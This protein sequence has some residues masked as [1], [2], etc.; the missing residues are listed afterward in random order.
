MA[1]FS[2]SLVN[3]YGST[4]LTDY[5]TSNFKTAGLTFDEHLNLSA[6]GSTL[7]FSMLKYLYE[8]SQ[9]VVNTPTVSITYGS[10]IRCQYNGQQYDFAV[11]NISYQ[12]LAENLQL[13]FSAQDYFQFETSQLG[14]G[15][16]ITSDTTDPNYFGAQPIDNWAYKII[17]DNNLGWGYIPIN[18]ANRDW[19]NSALTKQQKEYIFNTSNNPEDDYWTYTSEEYTL[20]QWVSFECSESSAYNALKQLASDNG[21]ILMVDYGSHNCWFAPKQNIV[22]HGYYFNPLNNLQQFAVKGSAQNLITVLNV[23]GPQDLN[24]QE[25]TLVPTLPDGVVA[26]ILSDDWLNSK[27]YS[28][29]YHNYTD[30]LQF[31][32]E[33]AYTPWL[34]NKL[35]DY[36]FF[37]DNHLLLP[38]EA[39]RI[40]D[41][42]YDKLR[43]IN[44]RMLVH[45][46]QYLSRYGEQYQ[47]NTQDIINAES[48]NAGLMG[49]VAQIANLVFSDKPACFAVSD[50]DGAP[51]IYWPETYTLYTTQYGEITIPSLQEGGD[52]YGK[53]FCPE[54]G[55]TT[56]PACTLTQ[57]NNSI[58]TPFT[59]YI[60]G[61]AYKTTWFLKTN[62]ALQYC[63]TNA[64]S[65]TDMPTN[66]K[67]SVSFPTWCT[68]FRLELPQH[69][70]PKLVEIRRSGG[71]IEARGC[72]TTDR[73]QWS[74]WT[75]LTST[76]TV[77]YFGTL[78]LIGGRLESDVSYYGAIRVMLDYGSFT[79]TWAYQS[80]AITL[81]FTL[82]NGNLSCSRSPANTTRL[83]IQGE[84]IT[85]DSYTFPYSSEFITINVQAIISNSDAPIRHIKVLTGDLEFYGRDLQG[86]ETN[87]CYIKADPTS[88]GLMGPYLLQQ[89][90]NALQFTQYPASRNTEHSATMVDILNQLC[91]TRDGLSQTLS[92]N[93]FEF[94]SAWDKIYDSY[95][96]ETLSSYSNV[97]TYILKLQKVSV[98]NNPTYDIIH[99]SDPYYEGAVRPN[100]FTMN[101][102]KFLKAAIL[103]T[104]PDRPLLRTEV[105]AY[106][107]TTIS[108][109]TEKWHNCYAAATGLGIYWPAD[110]NN[111]DWMTSHAELVQQQPELIQL[112]SP[113][114][115]DGTGQ[116]KIQNL[117]PN[118]ALFPLVTN[119]TSINTQKANWDL[120][121]TTLYRGDHT[122][123]VVISGELDITQ[124]T[125]EPTHYTID[126]LTLNVGNQ[127]PIVVN[128]ATFILSYQYDP[129]TQQTVVTLAL[130]KPDSSLKKVSFNIT[131][132]D[133]DY[134]SLQPQSQLQVSYQFVD[135]NIYLAQ[136]PMPISDNTQLRPY[137]IEQ[138]DKLDTANIYQTAWKQHN[139][140]ND[141]LKLQAILHNLSVWR[142]SPNIGATIIPAQILSIPFTEA[143]YS[144]DKDIAN[145][146]IFTIYSLAQ[147][148]LYDT[149]VYYEMLY[150]HNKYW[151]TLYQDYPGIFRESAYSNTTATNSQELYVAAKAELD[152]LS[153]PAFEYTLAGMDIY[154]YN[155]DF[156]PTRL[157]LGDQIRVDYQDP[158]QLTD[159]LN[160]ALREPLYI[161][162]ISHTLRNDGDYQFTVITRTA[163][164][165]MV[166][167]FAK[168]LNFGR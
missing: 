141:Q 90:H 161:T 66:Q 12:F 42:L 37:Q 114:I 53:L 57:I 51:W 46:R 104:A 151:Q 120:V 118:L 10:L 41:I 64:L 115:F 106:L 132:Y 14:I 61:V 97:G 73:G 138:S 167:R 44:G 76:S 91:G 168:L 102:I 29:L 121:V 36:S 80:S 163:T 131:V 152:N 13:T 134:Q 101:D 129:S 32:R 47:Q 26:W 148:V 100:V 40:Q 140:I 33:V 155:S 63:G 85:A 22:F 75:T 49:D 136:P 27:Y 74:D 128:T 62:T 119:S 159:T 2:L 84:I 1:Q 108:Y 60:N 165:S 28:N 125:S 45:Q 58:L 153:K 56:Y 34:E 17:Q 19:I 146:N 158:D 162:G 30:N 139:G 147:R 23:S 99:A 127:L 16:T 35:I 123:P 68:K 50:K 88:E 135:N 144:A 83:Q 77:G 130:D 70:A 8:G 55:G 15:Y 94:L 69:G 82:N 52:Y 109:F 79:T 25:I 92:Q 145:P 113:L 11:T 72:N 157:K 71:N 48:L 96:N 78:R 86:T 105:I 95:Q 111:S 24:N 38:S 21:F 9:K 133:T 5:D 122:L 137:F 39:Q 65:A 87:R 43:I 124:T 110:W 166:Q 3:K 54:V 149:R 67:F 117:I 31:Q 59:F 116:T 4:V 6:D 7:E 112:L 93:A 126:A 20:N 81:S 103:R 156:T 143:T 107:Q 150:E 160:A 98:C 154:M 142:A 89:L 164:D 18:Q